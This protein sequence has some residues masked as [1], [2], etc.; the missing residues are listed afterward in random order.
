M[1]SIF[2][3]ASFCVYKIVPVNYDLYAC[4]SHAPNSSDANIL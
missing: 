1:N 3:K 2:S 4:H